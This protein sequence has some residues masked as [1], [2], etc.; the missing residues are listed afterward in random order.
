MPFLT[1]LNHPIVIKLHGGAAKHKHKYLLTLYKDNSVRLCQVFGASSGSVDGVRGPRPSYWE[2]E[3]E[4][5]LFRIISGPRGTKYQ[6]DYSRDPAAFRE[7]P[8]VGRT[9]CDFLE[10]MYQ[11]LFGADNG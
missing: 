1:I 6:V 5:R 3:F 4:G 2:D 9:C 7:D 8:I 10:Y 11:T